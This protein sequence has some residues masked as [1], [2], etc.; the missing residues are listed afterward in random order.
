MYKHLLLATDG[1]EVAE[2]ALEHGLDLARS[3]GAEVTV[4]TV[5]MPW[6]SVAYGVVESL[7][8][9]EA[10][11]SA[12]RA[13]AQALLDRAAKRAGELGVKCRTIQ[14]ADLNPYQAV[15]AAAKDGN[16]DLIVVGAHGRRGFER[17]LLGSETTKILTHSKCPVLVWRG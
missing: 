11:E 8:N 12:S 15:I 13:R 14:V 7:T 1:T 6:S 17:L 9:R 5:T 4:L 10:Y 3:V 16:C 2:Q